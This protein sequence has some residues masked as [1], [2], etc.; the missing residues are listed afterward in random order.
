MIR[1]SFSVTGD[2]GRRRA[3]WCGLRMDLELL[4][5]V[6]HQALILVNA[7]VG[8]VLAATAAMVRMVRRGAGKLL[9]VVHFTQ[10]ARPIANFPTRYVVGD[11]RGRDAPTVTFV[12]GEL[13]L[14]VPVPLVNLVRLEAEQLLK[15]NNF[16]LVPNRILLELVSQNFIL[17]LVL[18][19]PR[20]C[21]LRPS[22][23]VP[24][25][26][27]GHLEVIYGNW[28]GLLALLA[29]FWAIFACTLQRVAIYGAADPFV[30]SCLF[31]PSFTI[32]GQLR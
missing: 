8:C 11:V 7:L 18:S 20:L 17:L 26:H 24:D 25:D 27:F 10:V 4:V 13:A 14:H 19:Q 12:L 3:L 9:N 1:S 16:R 6:A 2:E 32:L 22:T 15:L 31:C 23:F 28:R 5:F 30:H 21:F 29:T